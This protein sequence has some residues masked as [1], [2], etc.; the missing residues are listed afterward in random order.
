MILRSTVERRLKDMYADP[1]DFLDWLCAREGIVDGDKLYLGALQVAL[2]SFKKWSSA[3]MTNNYSCVYLAAKF[4]QLIP[5]L[6][7]Y[8]GIG[9]IKN[10][11]LRE[12]FS[13]SSREA[14]PNIKRRL[15]RQFLPRNV[16][17][18]DPALCRLV[19]ARSTRAKLRVFNEFKD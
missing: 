16:F 4:K 15:R 8:R 11:T 12:A 3:D 5:V 17:S 9:T 13:L 18:V 2:K 6:K 19:R 10:A 14:W 1:L 7:C